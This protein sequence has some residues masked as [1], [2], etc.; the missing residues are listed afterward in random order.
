MFKMTQK[1]KDWFKSFFEEEPGAASMIRLIHFWSF[2]CCIVIPVL[3]WVI[4]S[5]Y[6]GKFLPVDGTVSAFLLGAFVTATGGKV[7]QAI[8]GEKSATITSTKP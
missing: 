6:N 8:F 2:I 3:I 1:T 5:I 7:A 4:L